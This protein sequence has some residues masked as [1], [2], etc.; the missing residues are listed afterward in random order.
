MLTRSKAHQMTSL[1]EERIELPI[2][3]G[4]SPEG[5]IRQAERYFRLNPTIEGE[6]LEWYLWMEDRFPFR[7]WHDFK[8][9]LGKRFK[10]SETR[11]S[12]QQLMSLQQATSIREYMTEFERIVAFLP[13]INTEV[14]EDAYVWGLKPDIRSELAM[15]KPLEL[16]ETMDLSI[17]AEIHIREIQDNTQVDGSRFQKRRDK[18]L[19][20][21]CNEK[22]APGHRCKK[23]LN[24]I[25]VDEDQKSIEDDSTDEGWEL[26][27]QAISN[28]D[29]KAFIAHVS[30]NSVTRITQQGTLKRWGKIHD[31]EVSILI[32]SGATHNFLRTKII[33]NLSLQMEKLNG[34]SIVMGNGNTVAGAAIYKAIPLHAQGVLIVQDFLLLELNGTDVILGIQWLRT[35]G[36]ILSNYEKFI[37]RFMT[38]GK[39]HIFKGDPSIT[40]IN[41][42]SRRP[43]KELKSGKSYM[44]ELHHIYSHKDPNAPNDLEIKLI[45]TEVIQPSDSPY[46]SPALLVM[47]KDDR[48]RFCI[49]YRA[50]N[51]DTV[52]NRYPI[53]VVD[54]LLDELY[55]KSVFSKLDLK[56][57]YYQIRMKKEDVPKTTFK[58]HHGH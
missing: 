31:T 47:K 25:I 9:Q 57:G 45:S 3:Q 30:L 56:S 32:D 48:W 35:L 34:Y 54:K 50:L 20:Y 4:D 43:E 46:A 37:M 8:S 24:I 52:P 28:T 16:R 13:H 29:E 23:E 12:L 11:S 38:G 19:C 10:T 41:T 22:F 33:D 27:D 5:W 14:L 58:T 1:E 7:D 36:W 39:V 53:P 26:F 6:A 15:H 49:D 42:S 21:Y 51:R 2:F 17:Q 44:V 55:E 18:R 40:K